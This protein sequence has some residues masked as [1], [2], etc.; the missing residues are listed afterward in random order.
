M[1]NRAMTEKRARF[2]LHR[3]RR[4]RMKAYGMESGKFR[5]LTNPY[6][7]GPRTPRGAVKDR[8]VKSGKAALRREN[9]KH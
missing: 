3:G 1:G 2:R 9:K 6:W 8:L 4:P 7:S 5:Q